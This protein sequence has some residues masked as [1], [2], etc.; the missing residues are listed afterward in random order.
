MVHGT[1]L[2]DAYWDYVQRMDADT[3][4]WSG[5]VTYLERWPDVSTGGEADH[6]RRLLEFAEQAEL[7]PA[8]SATAETVAFTARS[9][10]DQLTWQ[11]ELRRP[12]PAIGTI[13]TM[14]VFLGRF[15]L[16]T[17][18]HGDAY[19]AKLD[20]LPVFLTDLAGRLREAAAAGRTPITTHVHGAIAQLDRYLASPLDSDPVVGQAPPTEMD[21][22]SAREFAD[23]IA[24]SVSDIVRPALAG[25]REVL[26]E[27][28]LPAARND[29]LPG[30]AHLPGGDD[31]YR[32]LLL[33]ATS[34]SLEAEEV[35]AIGEEQV[36]RLERELLET[37]GPLLGTTDISQI[38]RRLREDPELHYA[39]A[40]RLVDDAR[41]ALAVAQLVAPKWFGRT[42]KAPCVATEITSGALAFYSPPSDDGTK[43]GT[44]FFNVGDPSAWGTFQLQAITYHEAVP[45]HHFQVAGALETPNLH[46]VHSK[47]FLPAYGEG[48]GLYSE[49]LADEMGLYTSE[50]DRIGMLST[51]ALRACRLVVDTGLHGYGWSRQQAIDYMLAHTPLT[52]AMVEGEVDRYI[53]LP[54]QA[55][56]YM[57]GRLEIDSIRAEAEQTAGAKFDISGFHDAVLAHGSI[58]LPTLRRRVREWSK[59]GHRV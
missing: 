33:A 45:G 56:S 25:Y 15:P 43:P 40:D 5:D 10:A 9:A 24:T 4:L 18:E 6:R 58:P 46:P 32:R 12:N 13:S 1:A 35:H 22:G 7:L 41:A 23:R 34:L 20:G 59:S 53:G 3:A 19:L 39:D 27:V 30:L 29:D 54:G 14:L 37:A 48:W 44:F 51:D 49:R 50:W 47:V 52:L 11:A 8:G 38:H 26:S 36:A 42:P 21:P 2:F 57:I 17:A 28:T 55:T 31:V 16:V